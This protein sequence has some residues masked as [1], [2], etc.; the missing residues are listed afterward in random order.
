MFSFFSSQTATKQQWNGA[1]C[2]IIRLTKTQHNVK[3]QRIRCNN[4]GEFSSNY[5]KAFCRN[6]GIRLEYTLPYTPQ[7][8]GK[9]ERMY[10]LLNKVRTKFSETNLPGKLGGE[11]MQCSLHM[12]WIGPQ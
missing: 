8:N 1:E 3:T 7:E 11:A 10:S 4:G 6:K 2:N 9:A 12:N 5:F